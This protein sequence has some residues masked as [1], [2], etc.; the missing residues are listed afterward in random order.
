MDRTDSLKLANAKVEHEHSR[1]NTWTIFF[2]GST[3]SVFTLWSQFKDIIPP[4][5]PCFI[6][7][8]ISIVWVFVALGARRVTSSWIKVIVEI[9]DSS[10]NDFMPN[11]LYK[12]YE[13]KHSFVKDIIDFSLYRVTKVMTYAGIA[14][15]ML[16]TM[17][18]IYLIIK[19]A[20]KNLQTIEI[21]NLS[22]LVDVIKD[23]NSEVNYTHQA[24]HDIEA[25]LVNIERSIKGL[26]LS[27]G[28]TERHS[29]GH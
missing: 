13:C 22:Q 14:S 25:R 17:L 29:A 23:H 21:K 3:V 8:A 10:D 2:F 26:T 12:H 16:F 24:L 28:N 15:A 6:G 20:T 7:A 4:Y 1:W 11:K 27:T 19:P 9:E 5:V 18:G